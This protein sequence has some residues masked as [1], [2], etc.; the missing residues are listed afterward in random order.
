VAEAVTD[1]A[2]GGGNNKIRE[3]LQNP[4]SPRSK[5]FSLNIE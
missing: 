4:C 5:S 2:A 1:A 3:K